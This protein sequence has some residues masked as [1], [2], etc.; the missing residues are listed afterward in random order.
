MSSVSEKGLRYLFS[1]NDV[2]EFN[3]LEVVEK[4]AIPEDI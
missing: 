3:A 1:L 4:E 2:T